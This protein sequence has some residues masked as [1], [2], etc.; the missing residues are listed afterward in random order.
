[1]KKEKE[2]NKNK[3]YTKVLFIAVFIYVLYIFIGQQKTLNTYKKNQEYYA[4]QVSTQLAYQEELTKAKD[5]I[6]S[7]E[8]IEKIAREKLDM[9]LP[10]ERVYIDKGN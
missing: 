8:Y 2:N 10:N 3:L 5:N 9:Y 7:K 1:M 4:K 6:D